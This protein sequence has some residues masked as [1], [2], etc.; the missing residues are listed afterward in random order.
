M[1]LALTGDGGKTWTALEDK[2]PFR[3]AVLFH[4]GA[5]IVAGTSGADIS[6]D[7]GKTWKKLSESNLN[8]IGAAGDLIWA[9][10]PKGR[11]ER[12]QFSR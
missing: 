4:K 3:S 12:Y 8:A 5:I 11:I 9:A 10:G 1:T 2:L 7:G 6:R